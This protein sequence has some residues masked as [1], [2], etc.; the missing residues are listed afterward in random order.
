MCYYY[1]T[2]VHGASA[3]KEK[4]ADVSEKDIYLDISLAVTLMLS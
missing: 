4:R 2:I 1:R 3:R